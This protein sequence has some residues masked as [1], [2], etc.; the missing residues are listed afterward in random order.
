[1]N[2]A[3]R[4]RGGTLKKREPRGPV[5]ERECEGGT[6]LWYG[7]GELHSVNVCVCVCVWEGEGVALCEYVNVW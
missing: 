1:M 3:L 2:A 6:Q 4:G 7:M 5:N